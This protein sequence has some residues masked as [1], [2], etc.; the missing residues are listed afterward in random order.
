MYLNDES[1]GLRKVD[2]G[3]PVDHLDVERLLTEW[4]WL[5]PQKLQL[6]SRS[7]FGDLVLC[8]HKG[9]VY[10]LDVDVGQI[11]KITDTEDQFRTMFQD[12]EFREK[13]FSEA[14]EREAALRGLIPNA[15]QCI[16]FSTPL[17][18]K[19]GMDAKP[20]IADLYEC[21]SFLGD[22]NEQ[23]RNLPDGTE[24]TFKFGPKPSS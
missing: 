19:T 12:A 21:V 9:C 7:A 10:H 11:I 5:C 4:R 16:A 22:I 8:D 2:V 17:V 3:F 15:D 18:L 6:I 24:I 23:I 1:L 13:W 20:Y 14:D